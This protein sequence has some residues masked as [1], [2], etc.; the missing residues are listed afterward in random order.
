MTNE[1]EDWLCRARKAEKLALISHVSPDGDTVGATLAL[2]LAFLSLGKAVD[3]ICDGEVPANMRFLEGADQYITPDRAKGP[4]DAAIAVDVSCRELMGKAEAVFDAAKTRLVID[5]HATN[6][7]YGEANVIVRGESACCLVVYDIIHALGV[8]I[9]LPMGTCLMLGL[10]TDTGHFQ[11]PATSARTLYA[12]AKLL[13]L[14]V[15]ISFLTR[16]IYRTQPMEKVNLTRIAYQNMR[17]ELGG[18]VG[19]IELTHRDFEETGCSFGQ[20]DGLVNRALE[21]EGVRMAIM[22][23]EREDGIKMS[24]RAVEPDTINDIAVLFGGGGHAQAAGCTI[25]APLKEAVAQVLSAIAQKL[26]CQM[27]KRA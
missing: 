26:G 13:E 17:F 11:Y 1:H 9:T 21:V 2:R 25:H 3:I 24:M 10:S 12:A 14:G 15:D 18:Q 27:E 4:Y 5:H 16:K 8:E 20:A 23:S 7:A 19:V 6:P 22:A